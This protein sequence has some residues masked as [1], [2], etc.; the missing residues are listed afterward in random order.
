MKK[1]LIL[2]AALLFGLV[3]C[4]DTATAPDAIG[5]KIDELSN[6]PGYG[7]FQE[8]YNLYDVDTNKINTIRQVFNP[9]EF[10]IIYFTRPSCS[11]PGSHKSFPAI[12]KILNEAGVPIENMEF[13]S[14]NSLKS[15]HPY[16]SLF[17]LSYLPSFVIMKNGKAIYS[18]ID[19]LNYNVYYG[20]E[21]PRK[22]EDLLIEGFKK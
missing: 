12:N 14:L 19:T 5:Y 11:C 3:A 20:I 1:L 7:W 16:D 17:Q 15:R 13:Y 22:Y 18:V 6:L 2:T 10:K 4:S 9:Q 21:Y 8:E